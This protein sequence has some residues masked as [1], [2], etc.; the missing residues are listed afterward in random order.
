MGTFVLM[1]KSLV[2]ALSF[3]KGF[4]MFRYRILQLRYLDLEVKRMEDGPGSMRREGYRSGNYK[5]FRIKNLSS[6]LILLT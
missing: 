4:L 5:R 2:T 1:N 3:D 6:I